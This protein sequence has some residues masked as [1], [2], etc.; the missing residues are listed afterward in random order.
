[1]R[2][3]R[4]GGEGTIYAVCVT[5]VFGRAANYE[6]HGRTEEEGDTTGVLPTQ[7]NGNSVEMRTHIAHTFLHVWRRL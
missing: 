5:M 6:L 4:D 2:G 1:M 7:P 3:W